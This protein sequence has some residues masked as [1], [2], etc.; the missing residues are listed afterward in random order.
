MA[1]KKNYIYAFFEPVKVDD[2]GR[3]EPD[4]QYYKCWHGSRKTFKLTKAM[5]YSLTST[6]TISSLPYLTLITCSQLLVMIGHLSSKFPAIYELYQSLQT[7][8]TL[9]TPFEI[10]IAMASPDVSEADI[11]NHLK[12]LKAKATTSTIQSAFEKQVSVST[13]Q[14]FYFH[15]FIKTCISGYI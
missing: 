3:S 6:F 1:G 9:P 14:A 4:A 5:R 15:W 8:S 7:R 11:N 12:S 2:N 13:F 10:S